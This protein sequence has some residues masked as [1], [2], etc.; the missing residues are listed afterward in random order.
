MH[1][2][3]FAP[4]RREPI[5][6]LDFATA[7]CALGRSDALALR[8]LGYGEAFRD[9]TYAELAEATRRCAAMLRRLGLRPGETVAVLTGRQPE[10]VVAALGIW[11]AGGVY[12][13]I[14]ADLGPEPVRARLA[15]GEASMVIATEDLYRRVVSPVGGFLPHLRDA[16]IVGRHV[17]VGCRDFAAEMDKPATS[18]ALDPLPENRPAM[19]HF[20]S[21]TTAPAALGGGA[22]PKAVLHDASVAVAMAASAGSA[23]GLEP[24]EM[25]WCTAEPGWVTHTAYGL[26]APLA[27]GGTVLLDEVPSTPTRCLSVLEDQPVAV[28]YTTPTVIRG[29]I[30]GGAAPARSFRPRALRLAASVGEP[31]SRDAV[32]W[33]QAVLGVPFRDTWWQTE[34]GSI[35]LAHAPAETPQ[36]GSM[37]RPLPGVEAVLVRRRGESLVV[38]DAV[39]ASGEMALRSACLPPWRSLGGEGGAL[40]EEIEGLHLSGDFV[41]RDADGYYWFLGREDEVIKS[42]GRMIGPFEVEAVLMAHPAVAEAGVVGAPDPRV[43]ERIVA[44]VAVNPGFEPGEGLRRELM[45]YA[46]GQLGETL[47]PDSIYFEQDLPRTPSGKIIR[48]VLKTRVQVQPTASAAF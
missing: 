2:N 41:R 6:P 34:T 43:H 12:C 4:V 30:G 16:L 28:W 44:F 18:A 36:A 25:L 42:S 1:A 38:I 21:G 46:R 8:W 33:G 29:L 20:T 13:P 19:I 14:F 17:P 37:G 15:L 26:V 5:D 39:E 24:G 32:E 9:F 7:Q 48:R 45:S 40:A 47:T 11:Q 31:L 3:S 27:L 10:T 22:P 35:V 23:F